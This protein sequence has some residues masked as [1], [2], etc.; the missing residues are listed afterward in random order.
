MRPVPTLAPLFL[1]GAC[2]VDPATSSI[3]S[4][5]AD[6]STGQSLYQAN[7]QSCHGAD[8]ASGSAKK[9]V[10]TE[11]KSNTQ[12]AIATILSGDGEMPSFA[13]TLTDQ[14]IADIV[15][16]IKGL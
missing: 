13:S 7:C 6:T 15:G 2:G 8:A 4:L 9:P 10:A 14:Q 1:L 16:Y 3:T 11:V 5:T 12:A